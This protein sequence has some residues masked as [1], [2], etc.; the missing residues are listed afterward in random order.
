MCCFQ[1]RK[2]LGNLLTQSFEDL[3][4]G[5]IAEAIRKDTLEGRLHPACKIETCPFYHSKQ[6]QPVRVTNSKYPQ[7]F[8]IDLPTQHCNIGGE[9]PTEGAPAC[10]MCERHIKFEPQVDRLNEVCQVMQPYTRYVDAIHIQGISEPFWKNR[11]FE[12]IELLGANA[13]KNKIRFSTTTN[14]TVFHA[15][16][17]DQFLT[18]PMTAI[19]FSMDACTPATFRKIRRLDMYDK[20]VENLMR[21]ASKRTPNQFLRI[22]NN[23]NLLNIDEVVGMVE[24]AAAAKVDELEFNPTYFVPTICVDKQNYKLFQEASTKIVEAS[25]MLGVKTTFLRP[26]TLDFEKKLVQIT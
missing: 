9:N 20:I 4:W 11:I 6:L 14:G 19:T 15:K 16:E 2:C 5:K 8:E 24:C 17:Q 7:Q 25:Q 22:H 21:Y 10:I 12:V 26:L 23:I 13:F 1:H 18:Y 3:W